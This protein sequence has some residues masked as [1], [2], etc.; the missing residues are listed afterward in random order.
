[1]P[2]W[3]SCGPRSPTEVNHGTA[4][5]LHC[6]MLSEREA[7]V[8]HRSLVDIDA[9]R[10]RLQAELDEQVGVAFHLYSLTMT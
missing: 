5:V 2:S 8:L 10:D 1:M 4:L 9:E 6:N 7:A 3:L